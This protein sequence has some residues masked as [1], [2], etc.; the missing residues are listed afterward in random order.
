MRDTYVSAH[1]VLVWLGPATKDSGL[2]MDS[3]PPLDESIGALPRNR[4]AQHPFPSC[5][6]SEDD[7]L[8]PALIDL[9]KRPWYDRLWVRQEVILAK[10]ID[11]LCGN[12]SMPWAAFASF[13]T[14]MSELLPFALVLGFDARPHD[15]SNDSAKARDPGFISIR[16]IDAMR[17]NEVEGKKTPFWTYLFMG[18]KCKVTNPLDRVYGLL[19]L[20]A[21][22][23]LVRCIG[24]RYDWE[25]WQGYLHFCKIYIERDP[26]LAL[27]S[28]AGCV[29]KPKELP[30]WCPNLDSPPNVTSFY[31]SYS[32]F[33][34]GFKPGGPR[35]SQIK[36][37]ATSNT[38][39][40]PGFRMDRVKTVTKAANPLIDKTTPWAGPTGQVAKHSQYHYECRDLF[41]QVYP[42]VT[43]DPHALIRSL[44]AGHL[45]PS[46][47]LPPIDFFPVHIQFLKGLLAIANGGA[48]PMPSAGEFIFYETVAPGT[49][50][51]S[52]SAIL[53][54]QKRKGGNR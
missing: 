11:V 44:V 36:T 8:W 42:T 10:D 29:L 51:A 41:R 23:E 24:S 31:C 30:S 3:I 26:E 25:S 46:E 28:M 9:Y 4:F 54:Y 22:E 35:Y 45:A 13:A 1:K 17:S 27:F 18:Q 40:V 2:A 50:R 33:C 49:G 19:G 43:T 15:C 6:P 34:A 20:L 12:R 53:H 47:P 52:V 5:L 7:P 21:S 38:I 16:D 32:G 37:S 14:K 39:T 48:L